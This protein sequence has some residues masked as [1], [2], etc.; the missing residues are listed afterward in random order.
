M[1]QLALELKTWGGKRKGAGRPPSGLRA[2]V[3]HLLRD[4]LA[5]GMQGLT[6]RLARRLNALGARKG[7]VFADRYHAH[8][9][10]T[11]AETAN[12]LRYV[13]RNFVHHARENL[14]SPFVDPCSSARWL[15]RRPPEDA[16]VVEARTW[17]L[18]TAAAGGASR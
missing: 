3:S 8:V 9:L 14:P 11:R 6:I 10:R 16:P 17:L 1:K 12:A 4:A 2:G 5:R 18:R 13:A 15:R 7:K